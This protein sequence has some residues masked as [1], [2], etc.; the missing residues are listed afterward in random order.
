MRIEYFK[1]VKEDLDPMVIDS[2]SRKSR[3]P[4]SSGMK[5]ARRSRAKPCLWHQ[6]ALAH[7]TPPSSSEVAV[8]A[9]IWHQDNNGAVTTDHF[10]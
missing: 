1:E 8:T 10:R 7:F 9:A 6:E 5:L 2:L 3:S 4:G